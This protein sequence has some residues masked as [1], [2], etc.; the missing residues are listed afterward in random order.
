M[1]RL[2]AWDDLPEYMKDELIRPYYDT[3]SKRKLSIAIK[4]L[5]DIA[6]SLVLLIILSPVM[7]IIAIAIRLDTEGPAIFK[8]ERVTTNGRNFKILKF[9]TM[10]NNAS[11]VG[12]QVTVDRDSR[13]TKVGKVLRGCRLA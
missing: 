1:M 8:Q 3:L 2:K 7:L 4:R 5:F 11:F 6:F 12:T 9:R 10:I 13:V